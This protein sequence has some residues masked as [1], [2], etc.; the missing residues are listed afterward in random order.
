M[1]LEKLRKHGFF[2]YSFPSKFANKV[3]NGLGTKVTS[4]FGK[5]LSRLASEFD[6]ADSL[7]GAMSFTTAD[8]FDQNTA[9]TSAATVAAYM[10]K[11]ACRQV[12]SQIALLGKVRLMC[13]K[14][15]ED[16][17]RAKVAKAVSSS[18]KHE[19]T[20][21]KR[22]SWWDDSSDHNC[23]L[24]KKLNEHG[25]SN[26]SANTDGFGSV[27]QDK[28]TSKSLRELGLTKSIIQQRA[29]QLVRELHQAEE[30]QETMKL[31]QERRNRVASKTQ[32][33][34]TLAECNKN[35]S[36]KTGATKTVQTGLRAF[37]AS[38]KTAS[39]K[40]NVVDLSDNENAGSDSST[41]AGKRK[42]GASSE[43]SPMEKKAKSDNEPVRVIPG[44]FDTYDADPLSPSRSAVRT[45]VNSQGKI[46]VVNVPDC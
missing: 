2:N 10:D 8:M 20:W 32:G 31:L 46:E 36:K 42:S 28:S 6:V 30:Q 40:E 19:D 21:D 23:L 14:N 18:R 12:V 38:T 9:D 44:K 45:L 27:D 15:S 7:G 17:F 35:K 33:L 37:F 16:D 43:D 5:E 34:D 39:K 22:P 26:F 29:N 41:S 11:K 24:L 1:L 4:S 13:A 3:E 25:F